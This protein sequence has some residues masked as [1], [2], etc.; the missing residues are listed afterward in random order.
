MHADQL[1]PGTSKVA[2]GSAFPASFGRTDFWNNDAPPPSPAVLPDQR[3]GIVAAQEAVLNP[4]P[5]QH[6]FQ[7]RDGSGNL[8]INAQGDREG[9]CPY[10]INPLNTSLC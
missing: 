2:H 6:T 9:R 8:Q 4:I 7:C 3:K 5:K 1:T 10:T